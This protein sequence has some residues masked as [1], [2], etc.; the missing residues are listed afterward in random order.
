M[1]ELVITPNFEKKSAKIRGRCAAGEHVLVRLVGMAGLPAETLRLCIMLRE[2]L[3][4]VFP[5]A[6][7]DSAAEWSVDGEDL[8][9]VLN[10]NTEPLVKFAR[11]GAL[12]LEFI[13]DDP[14]NHILYFSEMHQVQPW[15][16]LRA[17]GDDAQPRDMPPF[18]GV[19]IST[20]TLEDLREAVRRLA[21]KG[22]A[23]II[24]SVA[25][26]LLAFSGAFAATVQTVPLNKLDF[27]VNP[28]VVTNVT[29]D[30][31]AQEGELESNR[32]EIA[33][34]RVAIAS[35]RVE[36][37]SNADAISTVS[38]SLAALAEKV[39][40]EANERFMRVIADVYLSAR[41]GDD[42][43]DG[44][45]PTNAVRTI[46]GAYA[47][48]KAAVD[49]QVL[50]GTN[51][52]VVAV[53]E[54]V[55]GSV[56]IYCELAAGIAFRAVGARNRTL[57]VPSDDPD[58]MTNQTPM[59]C[60]NGTYPRVFEMEGFTFTGFNGRHIRQKGGYQ[61]GIVYG[62]TLRRCLITGNRPICST[63]FVCGTFID[64]DITGNAPRVIS[65]TGAYAVFGG[66]A[67]TYSDLGYMTRI[68]NCHVWDNDFS[69]FQYFSAKV[70][71]ANC[72][73]ENQFA[74]IRGQ[75]ISDSYGSRNN[76]MIAARYT[77]PNFSDS[78]YGDTWKQFHK[79]GSNYFAVIASSAGSTTDP[80][81]TETDD[82]ACV[83]TANLTEDEI[84]A[85]A[86]CPSVRS[87]GS[88]DFGYRDSGFGRKKTA[89][90]LNTAI[91]GV[92]ALLEGCLPV[93]VPADAAAKGV[94]FVDT[95]GE[96]QNVAVA[97]GEG[98]SGSVS[99]NAL[100]NAASNTVARSAAVAI[101]AHSVVT[102]V[103]NEVR[104]QGVAVGYHAQA[105]A[106]NAIAIGAGAQ[107]PDE[108]ATH[109]DVTEEVTKVGNAT[110]ARGETSIAVGYS[111]KA[112]GA[113][114]VAVGRSAEAQASGSVQIG[115]GVNTNA[116]SLA[117][118][119]WQLME[120]DGQIPKERLVRAAEEIGGGM[121]SQLERLI[122]PGNMCIVYGGDDDQTIEPR[123]DGVC[124]VEI[125]KG[126]NDVYMAGS[127]V[128]LEPPLGSRNFD[129]VVTN[130]P[131]AYRW[132]A[133]DG[134]R[135]LV[136]VPE[137][138]NFLLA[139]SELP[140]GIAPTLRCAPSVGYVNGSYVVLSN[141]PIVVKVRQTA[142]N[143]IVVVAKPWDELEL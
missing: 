72:L 51:Q 70:E 18:D 126:T 116:N 115:P 123:L 100:L 135:T 61:R 90:T 49:A 56:E 73:F 114:S 107:H 66:Y 19:V 67:A 11:C 31:L 88:L 113:Q 97:I 93:E 121:L 83:Q 45:S 137:N 53:D 105:L 104:I 71:A 138:E 24:S 7:E 40:K 124:E 35:N 122:R 91:E 74:V 1:N 36:I 21:E 42:A 111:A 75:R 118:R 103:A 142:T 136:P 4:A 52:V 58:D 5:L 32:V 76:T 85:D 108:A 59:S 139:F 129:L 8:T 44:L 39:D 15:H 94:T 143:R 117:F 25:V 6:I 22:G 95:Y 14:S 82:Y 120:G 12:T 101:G 125:S 28:S 48:A 92:A 140:A 2:R 30:G 37:A 63:A 9:C 87:D 110:V 69:V 62:M 133:V 128:Y 20:K 131:Q 127:E 109:L 57:V 99:T 78:S 81:Y 16:S 98:A 130:I 79:L 64:C 96:D 106:S 17:S 54:G 86:S 141:A 27:D 26:A 13:L 80:F 77:N 46:A 38:N 3:F 65:D 29:F 68:F 23:K 34:N 60:D 47:A 50:D 102:N 55:Y 84:A 119:N 132:M 10:L 112:T 33:S 134:E 89:D 41:N 43:N